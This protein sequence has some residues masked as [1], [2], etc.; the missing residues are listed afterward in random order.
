MKVY[1][2]AHIRNVALV[3]HQ[4]SG[5]TMLAEAMLYASGA[6]NRMGAI[7]EGST[8]SDYHPSEKEREMSVFASLVH[9]EWEGHKINIIDTP[10]YPDFVGEVIG[11]LKVADT[12]IFVIDAAEGVQVGTE[13]AWASADRSTVPAMFVVNHIDKPDIKFDEIIEQVRERFGRGATIV[14]FP[15]AGGSRTIVDVLLMKQLTFPEGKGSPQVTDIEEQFQERAEQLHNELIENIAENDESLMELYFEKGTLTEDE[16]R[17][18]L[19]E[20]MLARQLFPIFLTSATKNVGVTRLMSFI[21]NVCPRPVEMPPAAVA[22]GEPVACDK[23]GEPVVFIYRTMAEHHVGDYSF[24]K[25]YS[26]TIE[27]G[28]DLENAQTGGTERLGQLFSI[29]GRDRDAV[30][31]MEAGD[32]GALVKLRDTHTNNTLRRK[33]SRV[34]IEPIEFP[35]PRYATAV[36]PMREGEEE[37]LAQG[38]HQL[39]E[40]DPSLKIIH[41]P[42]LNQMVLGG[43]GEMHL[44]ITRFRLNN[45]F[46]VDVEYYRPRVAYRETIQ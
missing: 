26:G 20:A 2:G 7:E 36:R 12:A 1:D 41:D 21:D 44:E 19:H 4:G 17:Q 11:S 33:G 3:G 8:V 37:K 27:S 40:E 22:E 42:H 6:I 34:V 32:L 45:R 14:Q 18:G 5:K 25:V 43:Q 28:V 46:G 24:F 23:N 9:A 38:F 35:A 29:N 13:L 16:M 10:G 31:K 39:A 15:T 30:T